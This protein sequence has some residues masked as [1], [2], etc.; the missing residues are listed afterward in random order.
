MTPKELKDTI[1]TL[2]AAEIGAYRATDA[3]ASAPAIS[4]LFP[5]NQEPG[6]RFVEGLE[7][8]VSF[9]PGRSKN[10]MTTY[11]QP[12]T[13]IT[14]KVSLIQH[15]TTGATSHN[16]HTAAKKLQSRFLRGYGSEVKVDDGVSALAEFT[17]LIP[18]SD[19][20]SADRAIRM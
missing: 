19:L 12:D 18:D 13:Q 15:P 1:A 11:D 5:Y 9:A 7:V 3:G 2:L 20:W 17:F 6:D 16:M 4:L 14:H 10:N 8:V